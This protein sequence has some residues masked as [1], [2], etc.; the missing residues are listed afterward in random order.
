MINGEF[1]SGLSG[2][3]LWL[4]SVSRSRRK[5]FIFFLRGGKGQREG[6]SPLKALFK[7]HPHFFKDALS[8]LPIQVIARL[9]NANTIFL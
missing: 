9:L 7:T 5:V 4:M 1:S 3:Y 6:F 2:H 8:K